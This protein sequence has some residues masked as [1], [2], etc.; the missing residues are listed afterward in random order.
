MGFVDPS[1]VMRL[2]MCATDVLI[3]LY[4]ANMSI[5]KLNGVQ[6]VVLMVHSILWIYCASATVQ[7]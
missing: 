7:I 2:D 5:V 3:Y 6:G 1:L 4:P